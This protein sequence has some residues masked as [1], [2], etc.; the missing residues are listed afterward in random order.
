[1]HGRK[2]IHFKEHLTIKKNGEFFSGY[3]E[4]PEIKFSSTIKVLNFE[5]Y[6]LA[7]NINYREEVN[8]IV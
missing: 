5:S 8:V 4:H 3:C 6:F 7:F 1:M 2:D